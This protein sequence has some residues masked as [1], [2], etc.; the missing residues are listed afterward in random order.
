MPKILI[1]GN[2]FDLSLGLPTS[3]SDFINILNS[4]NEYGKLD[5]ETIYRKSINY[6]QITENYKSFD[7]NFDKIEILKGEIK[8]NLWFKF[9]KNEFEIE[10]WI[11][12]ENKIEYVLKVL[13]SS[14]KYLKDNLFSKGSINKDTVNFNSKLFNN[15]VE[16]IQVLNKFNIISLNEYYEI[17]FNENYLI[18]K[19]DF[20]IDVDINKITKELIEELDNFKKI[21]NYYF[22]VFVFPFYFNQK[23]RVGKTLFSN[24]N[25]HYTFNYTPTFDKFY[26]NAQKTNFLHGKIDSSSNQIVLGINEIPEGELDKRYFIPFTKYFQKLNN[27][28]DFEF[29]TEF[30]KKKNVN[31]IFFFFGHSLDSSDSDY[32][33]EIFNF[34]NDLNSRIK[35]IVI[36]HHNDKSKSQLLL[37]LLNI[38][39]KDDI[40]K[41]MKNN[42]LV[43]NHID[44]IELKRE[45]DRD[46]TKSPMITIS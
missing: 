2:G 38:R 34:V 30:E 1:T 17:K 36:I 41:L 14:V 24:I 18:R 13:F 42:I 22:E 25:K 6:N 46:I 7:F 23:K 43:F 5:Y 27:N 11:D 28:T 26:A 8:S 9:F 3:Y 35:K 33:N 29:I 45:L 39:G 10:T 15:N 44:S 4:L 12:F 19:Y 37:N 32:I 21:F 31:Y 20:F 16:I 40:Q